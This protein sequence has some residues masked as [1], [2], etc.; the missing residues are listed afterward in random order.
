MDTVAQIRIIVTIRDIRNLSDDWIPK[1]Q[2]AKSE[3]KA[4]IPPIAT[5]AFIA[6]S[7]SSLDSNRKRLAEMAAAAPTK[8]VVRPKITRIDLNI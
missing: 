6:Q 2:I 7:N 4:I 1:G 8:L 3:P 5:S